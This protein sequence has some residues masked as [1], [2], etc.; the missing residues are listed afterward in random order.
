M[1]SPSCMLISGIMPPS[2][3]KLSCMALTAPQE[4][5]VVTTANSEEATMPKRTSLPSMLPPDKPERVH[6]GGAA[7]FRPIGDGDAGDEHHAHHRQDRPA[8]LLVADHAA[9]HVGEAAPIEKIEI[10]CTKFD[11][12]VG[13]SNGCAALALKKPPPLVPSI[14]IATWDATGPTAMVCLA[15][16]SVVAST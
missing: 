12:A 9:E 8:L 16:S 3:V 5:A 1:I 15:P 13:F 6:R 7:R 11:S 10:I 2:A 4:A 14:L